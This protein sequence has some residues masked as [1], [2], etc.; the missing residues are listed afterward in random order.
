M[1][2]VGNPLHPSN[3]LYLVVCFLCEGWERD[4][5]RGRL[6]G[7]VGFYSNGGGDICGGR[8]WGEHSKGV[9]AD[10]SKAIFTLPSYCCLARHKTINWASLARAQHIN[11]GHS[12]P[13][14]K[15]QGQKKTISKK[16][17]KPEIFTGLSQDYPGTVPAFS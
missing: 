16:T 8:E 10:V 11:F 14:R 13:P 12:H 6:G 17:H 1:P 9:C 2:S 3:I 5:A 15:I 7:G 4:E